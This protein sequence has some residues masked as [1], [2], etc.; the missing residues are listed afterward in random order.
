M[1]KINNKKVWKLTKKV[2]PQHTD[3]AGVMWHGAYLNF[4]EE[5]RIDALSQVGISYSKLSN[6]GFELPVVSIKI[7]YKISFI[8]GELIDMRTDFNIINKIRLHCKTLF[9]KENGSI[10]AES[11]VELV[12]VRKHDNCI[13][14]VRELPV[15]I[16][17]IFSLL[18]EGTKR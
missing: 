9:L 11:I 15:K 6:E 17:N 10:G 12:I 5:S 13:K 7:N 2:L 4:L 18:A 8:H 3:H 16:K 14:I 1:N